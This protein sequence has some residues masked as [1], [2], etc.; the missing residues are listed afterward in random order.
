MNELEQKAVMSICILAAFADGS[1]S[2]AERTQVQKIAEGFHQNP[3]LATAYQE[4]LN[5]KLTLAKAAQNVASP[6]AKAL[7]YEMA[8][9]VCHADGAISEDETRFLQNLQTELHLEGTTPNSIQGQAAQLAEAATPVAPPKLVPSRD[10]DADKI[11]LDA[12]ILTGALE[13]LPHSL[14]TM[15]IIPV[16]IRMVYRLGQQHGFELSRSHIQEFLAAVGVGLTSQVVEGFARKLVGNLA[17]T[18]GG[19]LLGGFAGVTTGAAV[20]FATTYALGHVAERYYAR[21]RTLNATELRQ[22]F[23]SLLAEGK[24]LQTRYTGQMVQKSQQINLNDLVPLI[25]QS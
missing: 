25:R 9:C 18:V 4:V 16:Q 20:S 13:L 1:Q 11:I 19:G 15:A 3:D 17:R 21:G 24:S 2:E 5:Q 10:Q 23:T 7:A 12:A 22:V 8:V 14:A 6:E